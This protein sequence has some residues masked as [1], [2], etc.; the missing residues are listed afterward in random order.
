MTA[1]SAT[2][3]LAAAPIE[4]SEPDPSLSLVRAAQS[5]DTEAFGELIRL[6][7]HRLFAYLCRITRNAHDA[8]DLA[9]DT[10]LK[11]WRALPRYEPRQ[12]FPVWLFTI[13]KRTALN[14]LRDR[15]PLADDPAPE[16]PDPDHPAALVESADSCDAI[17]RLARRL[18]PD[19][20][21][22]LWLRHAQGFSIVETARVMGKNS[23]H[24]R[25]LLHRGRNQLAELLA[26]RPDISD[27][28][29]RPGNPK[30]EN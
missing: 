9:Q 17:W 14:H 11:V 4:V 6:H 27:F 12:P 7:Q 2:F 21:E 3:P 15:K 5:G 23:I 28:K 29:S 30:S 19:Q 26:A 24:V 22:A 20:F 8:E 16:L 25:V 13:A 1:L 18:K 10:F